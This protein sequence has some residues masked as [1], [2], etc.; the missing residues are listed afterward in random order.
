M[1][2]DSTAD[3]ADSDADDCSAAAFPFV[4]SPFGKS[5][6]SFRGVLPPAAALGSLP[7]SSSPLVGD[8]GSAS[9]SSWITGEVPLG[10]PS[11]CPAPLTAGA[12]AGSSGAAPLL[13]NAV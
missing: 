12:V 4:A 6:P 8:P 10:P 11:H 7:L 2:A 1:G 5:P 9:S 3:P 13:V